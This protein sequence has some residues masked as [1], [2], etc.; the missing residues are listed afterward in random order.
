MYR[1][2]TL[3]TTLLLLLSLTACQ[4]LPKSPKASELETSG[5][6]SEINVLLTSIT[7]DALKNQDYQQA[8][9]SIKAM[10]LNDDKKSWGFIQSAVVSLPEARAIELINSALNSFTV[11]NSATQLF[12]ISKIL[13]SFKKTEPALETI[14]RSIE[15]D[16]NNVDARYWRARLL[17]VMKEYEKA[18]KD[19]KFVLKKE[20]DNETYS[21]QYATF[22]QETKQFD[23]AQKILSQH[24]Q[25]PDSL[26]KRIIFALQNED[27]DM[28][29][30]IYIKLKALEV[31]EKARNHK[32]FITAESAYWL[33]KYTDS[34]QFY[35]QVTGGDH[36]LDARDMISMILFDN[37]QYD[38]S[39]EVLHQ[40]QNAEEKYA[41]KAY[42]LEAQIYQIQGDTDTALLTLTRSLEILP[43]NAELLYD[44][45]MLYEQQDKMSKVEKD[46]LQII[47]D[48]PKN[49][50]ALNALGYSLADHDLQLEKAHEYINKALKLSPENAAIID[51][52]GWVQYKLGQYQ[53]AESNFQKA[54]TMDIED[55]ELYIHLYKTLL[56]LN[57]LEQAQKLLNE[58]KTHFPNNKKLSAL[59]TSEN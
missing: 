58:A 26:F 27:K 4:Q 7:M 43:N 44:R 32:S 54:L 10:I 41:I 35:R 47:K 55:L 22:L 42:R 38:D 29:N 56:K 33:E 34:E 19:F 21:G 8:S 51:S 5:Q 48:D 30:N 25:T 11:S 24:K 23:K 28:A 14:N 1:Y 36:Y 53:E 13:I 6:V 39:I 15:L 16:R 9:R 3:F 52:L 46:L 31:E 49:Y 50:E 18:E 57:K 2:K 59:A 12:G 45:A 37:Q 20:P 40:L 17:T